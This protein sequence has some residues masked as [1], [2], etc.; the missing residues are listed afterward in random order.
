MK[1][2]SAAGSPP[3]ASNVQSPRKSNRKSV[4]PAELPPKALGGGKLSSPSLLASDDEDLPIG[5]GF[6]AGVL[7]RGKH[8]S[9]VN[10]ADRRL[11]VGVELL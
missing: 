11:S 6:S 2:S 1:K 4:S 5:R 7:R 9:A 8:P 10:P 3:N